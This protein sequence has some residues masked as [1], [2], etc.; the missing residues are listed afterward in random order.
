[1]VWPPR[2]RKLHIPNLGIPDA[3]TPGALDE[4][5][6]VALHELKSRTQ[7][8]AASAAGFLAIRIKNVTLIIRDA[9]LGLMSIGAGSLFEGRNPHWGGRG[10]DCPDFFDFLQ[11]TVRFLDIQ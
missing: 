5:N 11:N 7:V 6:A 4:N 1:V 2:I 9:A 8:H 10:G 3:D